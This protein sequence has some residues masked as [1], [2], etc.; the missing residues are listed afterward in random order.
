[1]EYFIIILAIIAGILFK[2]MNKDWFNPITIFLFYW[3]FVVF[4]ASLQLY[5]LDDVSKQAEIFVLLGVVGWILGGLFIS[6]LKIPSTNKNRLNHQ[7]NINYDILMIFEMIV[8][9]Y[10]LYRILI[11]LDLQNSGVSWWAIRLMAT[12]GES[13]MGSLKGGIF[14][15]L[16]YECV[17]APIAYL[18]AP[19]IIVDF[20]FGKRKQSTI[21]LGILAMAFFSIA[22][23]SR[24]I[25]A[26]SLIYLLVI[27]I[28]LRKRINLTENQKKVFRVIPFFVIVLLVIIYQI[29]KLRNNEASILTNAYAY[30]SGSLPLLSHFIGQSYTNLRF[31]GVYTFFG[32]LYPI[33][34][35]LNYTGLMPYPKVYNDV[36][37]IKG[38]TELFV[39]IGDGIV[40]NSYT[41]LF[42]NFY[43][44][45]GYLGI[46]CFSAIF[47]MICG[48]VYKR[49]KKNSNQKLLILYLILLQFL[50][51]SVARIYTIYT[52]RALSLLWIIPLFL[53]TNNTKNQN[54]KQ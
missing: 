7:Q 50:L 6:V 52:T 18:I 22:T 53:R 42:Y 43:L 19:T 34:F 25:W 38:N 35:F 1:M 27:V 54:I 49:M 10:S 33:F 47:A 30:I 12:S 29:T 17:V 5:N 39:E 32:F 41:T 15:Q 40:M 48:Y 3:G 11:I 8:I 51:F 16:L 45:F 36:F 13:G 46:V 37:L 14:S 31:H 2:F 26:F 28:V 4:M 23:V 21:V 44:D 20:I 24:A 9:I